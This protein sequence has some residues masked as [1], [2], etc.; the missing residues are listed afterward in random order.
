MSALEN[1]LSPL[2]AE[3]REDALRY[4]DE[5]FDEAGPIDEQ[6][7][8]DD[9]GDPETIARQILTDN[10]V[11]PDGRPQ[12]MIDE[13]ITPDNRENHG[14]AQ[15]G[16]P[17]FTDNLKNDFNNMSESTRIVLIIALIVVTFPLWGGI[18]GGIF[19][20]LM[21]VIGIAIGLVAT[22]TF[23]G[24]GLT[25]MGFVYLFKAPPIGLC[26]LGAGLIVTALDILLI[27]PL[28]KWAFSMLIKLIQWAVDTIKGLINKRRS[29]NA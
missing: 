13:A 14:S 8:L 15:N 26:I 1:R 12:F 18:L 10:G 22:F 19:G 6:K 20:M 3:D 7:I 4:Y 21:A 2:G 24:V 11:D 29:A 23:A 16:T 17:S 28:V 9:L 5:L 27:F 25:I